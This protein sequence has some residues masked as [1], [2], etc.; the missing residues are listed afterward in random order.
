MSI[1][2]VAFLAIATSFIGLVGTFLFNE[3]IEQETRTVQDLAVSFAEPFAKGD[4]E[5]LY[6]MVRDQASRGRTILLDMDAKVQVDS[7]AQYNGMRFGHPEVVSIIN[8]PEMTDDHG[9]HRIVQINSKTQEDVA[10]FDFL[11][12]LETGKAWTGYFT[13]PIVTETERIGVVLYSVEVQDLVAKLRTIQ[14]DMLKYFLFAA[15]AVFAVS[16]V[17]AQIITKPLAELTEGIKRMARGDLA[18]RVKATGIDEMGRL[19]ATFNQM[20]EK[21]ENVDTIRNEFVSNASHELKTPLATMKI[22]LES[23]LYQ[24]DMPVELRTEFL[25]DINREL[26]RLGGI[27]TDLLTLVQTDTYDYKM[28]P[29]HFMLISLVEDTVHRLE[30]LASER[31]QEIVVK[32]NSECPIFADPQKLQQAI[33]NLIDNAIKYTQEKGTIRVTLRQE[34]KMAVLEIADNG[35]GIPK[36]D[37]PHIFDRFYR[38]DRARARATGG[39]GLGLSIVHQIVLLHQG[40]VTVHSEEGKGTTFRMELP[41]L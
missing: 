26:D 18:T 25:T 11:R 22:M 35:P 9:F 29:E 14:D 21:L 16:L 24:E 7:S 19:A 4:T 15:I 1:L 33:Y 41:M 38:V 37:Q 23:M 27:V 17:F 40:S 36:K 3:K 2:C 34:S 32:A 39:N 10:T 20:S 28:I 30:P 8:N 31:G 6:R 5:T 13:A 12:N